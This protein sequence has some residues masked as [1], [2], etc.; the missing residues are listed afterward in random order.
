VEAWRA[1]LN[2]RSE[3]VF[4]L[5]EL[6]VRVSLLTS[7]CERADVTRQQMLVAKTIRG[8]GTWHSSRTILTMQLL[9]SSQ[10]GLGAMVYK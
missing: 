9:A 6:R 8:E 1:G 5:K 7:T 4:L 2:F 10:S 3:G